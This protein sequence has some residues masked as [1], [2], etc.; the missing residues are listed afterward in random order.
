MYHLKASSFGSLLHGNIAALILIVFLLQFTFNLRW[1]CST[2]TYHVYATIHL[3]YRSICA[4][5]SV[6]VSQES[7]VGTV[8]NMCTLKMIEL[9]DK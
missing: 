2:H 7:C 8:V 1:Y 4:L 5:S 6:N 3:Y 9:L